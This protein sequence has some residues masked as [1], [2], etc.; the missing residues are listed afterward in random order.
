MEVSE[1]DM[2][3]HEETVSEIMYGS[4]SESVKPMGFMVL[5]LTSPSKCEKGENH[6]YS[7]ANK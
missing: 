5:Q 4:P 2:E 6:S 7:Y 3:V 1:E